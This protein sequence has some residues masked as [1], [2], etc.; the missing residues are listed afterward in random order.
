MIFVTAAILIKNNKIL[1]APRKP[2]DMLAN[3]WEFPGGKIELNELP[4]CCLIRELKEEFSIDIK[5]LK[6]FGE[7]IYKYPN[8]KIKLIAYKV[9]WL[10]GEIELIDHQDFKWISLNEID[11]FDFA[12]ADKP[13][14]KKLKKEYQN[15]L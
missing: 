5:I 3:K 1:I 11:K 14:I 4:E 8:F 2:T 13:L 10:S 6:Y 7:S 12:E 9:L 15:G